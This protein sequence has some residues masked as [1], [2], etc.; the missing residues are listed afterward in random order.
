VQGIASQSVLGMTMAAVAVMSVRFLLCSLCICVLLLLFVLHTGG[1]RGVP[2][3]IC[4]E[5]QNDLGIEKSYKWTAFLLQAF[6]QQCL[7]ALPLKVGG[8]VEGRVTGF[9]RSANQPAGAGGEL[10]TTSSSPSTPST[11]PLLH[12][13]LRHRHTCFGRNFPMVG[14][15]IA[16]SALAFTYLV[17]QSSA[18]VSLAANANYCETIM[19]RHLV[20]ARVCVI[21]CVCDQRHYFLSRF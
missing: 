8:G 3:L 21:S 12:L 4:T 10:S 11:L 2:C 20:C 15:G 16:R 17:V 19:T 6:L 13:P 14:A 18:G 1:Q 5:L 7:L 9:R